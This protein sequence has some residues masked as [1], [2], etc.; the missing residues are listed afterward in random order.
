VKQSK[1]CLQVFSY[2]ILPR[3]DEIACPDESVRQPPSVPTRAGDKAVLAGTDLA[4]NWLVDY[5]KPER[6]N[7]LKRLIVYHIRSM[8]VNTYNVCAQV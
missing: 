5:N 6:R 2:N 4:G 3:Q 7:K 1:V 8:I